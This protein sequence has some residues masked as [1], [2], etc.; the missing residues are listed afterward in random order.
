MTW[1]DL[2]GPIKELG[3]TT[4]GKLTFHIVQG[5]NRV[6]GRETILGGQIVS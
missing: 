5:Y 4:N 6:S 2:L 1:P 3:K